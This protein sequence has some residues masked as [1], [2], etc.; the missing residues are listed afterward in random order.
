[1]HIDILNLFTIPI[2]CRLLPP[3]VF[4][5][6]GLGITSHRPHLQS[7]I[8]RTLVISLSAP[9]PV[10]ANLDP[11][12]PHASSS[13]IASLAVKSTPLGRKRGRAECNAPGVLCPSLR[14]PSI[15]S[16]KWRI[17]TQLDLHSL[18]RAGDPFQAGPGWH[19]YLLRP[20]KRAGSTGHG[21]GKHAL[22]RVLTRDSKAKQ[23][24][25]THQT[26]QECC[27]PPTHHTATTRCSRRQ[28]PR[29]RPPLRVLA[30]HGPPS[31]LGP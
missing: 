28:G 3:R 11:T 29:P 12:S 4:E 1:M 7:S 9:S 20:K 5:L 6:V 24:Q 25:Q 17:L 27:P 30:D 21:P 14:S 10:F 16:I 18:E 22:I 13:R 23:K 26:Q 8:T 31:R 19:G 15:P 2:T